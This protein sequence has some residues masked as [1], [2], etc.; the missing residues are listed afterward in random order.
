MDA[1][2]QFINENPKHIDEDGYYGAQCWDLVAKYARVVVGCPKFPTGSGGAEG[3]FRIAADPI[4]QYFDKLPAS[5]AQRGDIAVWPASFSPPWG[6]TALVT[7]RNG[8]NATL[9][10]QNGN[11]PGGD[12]YTATRSVS[13]MSGVLRPKK[14]AIA[15]AKFTREQE[16]TAALMA[17]GSVPGDQYN[18]QFT[19]EDISSQSLDK[20]LQTWLGR[21]TTVTAEMEKQLAILATGSVY[22][23]D[24]NSQYQGRQLLA[25]WR[26]MLAFWLT[27]RQDTVGSVN[28]T[29]QLAE[30]TQAL[31]TARQQLQ[32]LGSRPTKAELDA[33]T[34]KLQT[35]EAKAMAMQAAVEKAN[36]DQAAAQQTGNAFLQWLGQQLNK[37]LG[38]G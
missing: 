20:F 9:Y 15:M 28:L 10:E 12:P 35:A 37:I 17:T 29:K 16:Q 25:V 26:D 38:K 7:G 23:K 18:Y 4:L 13:G 21:S 3:L 6:H 32:D 22:G 2:Q 1:V 33:V 5:Q 8:G 30:A 27:Q 36:A 19:V 11:N 34:A 24:Y 31:I 14:G